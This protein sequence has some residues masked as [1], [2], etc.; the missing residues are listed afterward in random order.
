M[1][2]RIT[3]GQLTGN[4]R[5]ALMALFACSSVKT[6]ELEYVDGFPLPAF[7]RVSPGLKTLRTTNSE[8]NTDPLDDAP[9]EYTSISIPAARPEQLIIS[10][11]G[12]I[13]GNLALRLIDRVPNSLDVS[14]LAS[15][16]IVVRFKSDWELLQRLMQNASNTLERVSVIFQS[17]TWRIPVL[18]NSPHFRLLVPPSIFRSSTFMHD[19]LQLQDDSNRLRFDL[20]RFQRL[21]SIEF[22][23]PLC[24]SIINP[25]LRGMHETLCSLPDGSTLERITFFNYLE[26]RH[27]IKLTD[28]EWDELDLRLASVTQRAA[29]FQHIKFFIA[30]FMGQTPKE[31]LRL[32]AMTTSFLSEKIPMSFKKKMIVTER[33]VSG[34]AYPGAIPVHQ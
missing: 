18:R 6:L 16:T 28:S 26:P 17:G 20:G 12:S 4:L 23:V 13:K 32:Y 34:F 9:E 24:F 22:W 7:R 21:R 14:H 30:R 33:T 31:Q 25:I 27:P 3:W 19:Q 29:Q 11:N 1:L 10:S 5:T 15:L 8:C 2:R